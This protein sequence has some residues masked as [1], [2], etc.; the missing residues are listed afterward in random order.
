MMTVVSPEQL[1][2]T[3]A[4]GKPISLEDLIDEGLDGHIAT[5]SPRWWLCCT[6]AHPAT[7]CTLARSSP[8]GGS[9]RASRR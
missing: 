5:A 8:R 4:A 2:F 9:P 3:D 7:G 6:M 1:L